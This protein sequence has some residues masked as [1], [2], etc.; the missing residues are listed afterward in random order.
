MSA[1]I[2]QHAEGVDISSP[3]GVAALL[4]Q[5]RALSDAD[6]FKSKPL[7]GKKLALLSWA[8]GDD[9]DREFVQAATA[10]GAHVSFVQPEF[11]AATSADQ[12]DATARLLSRLYDA[13]ECQHLPEPLV[14]R[15]ASR[16]NV[17]VFNGLALAGHCTSSLAGEL[18]VTTPL[19]DRRRRI[20]QAVLI[21]SM[22]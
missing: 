12:I 20:L 16:I 21:L 18:D 14:R 2:R 8:P 19:P 1:R 7:R 11:D 9:D 13:V 15:I 6:A 22:G 5:A 17:P 3:A 4:L 10:L